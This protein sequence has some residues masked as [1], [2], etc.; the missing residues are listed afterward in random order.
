MT[1]SCVYKMASPE[2]S[3]SNNTGYRSFTLKYFLQPCWFAT[4]ILSVT[5]GMGATNCICQNEYDPFCLFDC[6]TKHPRRTKWVP[7]MLEIDENVSSYIVLLEYDKVPPTLY[8][9]GAPVAAADWAYW[10]IGR[11]YPTTDAG[12]RLTR[13]WRLKQNS[14]VFFIFQLI[15]K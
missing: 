11:L 9:G 3:Q 15:K 2:C 4:R 10:L 8:L 12:L 13:Q 14:N 6:F 7:S 5:I 1:F